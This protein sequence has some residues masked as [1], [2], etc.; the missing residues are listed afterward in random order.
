MTL[1]ILACGLFAA[2]FGVFLAKFFLLKK[3]IR[4]LEKSLSEI[5]GKDTN[6]QVGTT[7]FDG[8]ITNLCESINNTLTFSRQVQLDAKRL[9]ADLKR[10][11]T[12]I[13][14]DLRT[15]LTSA[16]G[17]LQML[18][19]GKPC[20]DDVLRY[21]AV[22]WER[23]SA[24][25]VLLDSLFEFSKAMESE[26]V[27]SRVNLCNLLRDALSQFFPELDKK[28]FAVEVA[29]PETPIM[30]MCD[31]QAMTRVIQNLI[32]NVCVHGK[33][34]LRLRLTEEVPNTGKDFIKPQNLRLFGQKIPDS[35]NDFSHPAYKIEISNNVEN[36]SAIDTKKI[37]ERFYTVDASRSNKRTGLG[38]A[39]AKELTER[40]GGNIEASL[41]N[42]VFTISIQF[43]SRT[44]LQSTK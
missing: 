10:A 9:E 39:I 37:F 7:T 21:H 15:P 33:D 13:S 5:V 29:F 28:G 31:E 22:I 36:P 43:F 27:V 32:K 11:I 14:H 34:F 4:Q 35:L 38:L 23:L 44:F 16:K 40:M 20:E 18:L 8:D 30:L 6:A 12:N 41:E 2:G 42:R 3:D 1:L 17:Y 24:L 19:S 25:T 26:L